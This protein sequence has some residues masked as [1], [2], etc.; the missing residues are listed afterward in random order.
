MTKNNRSL[1]DAQ[2]P[3]KTLIAEAQAARVKEHVRAV[4][5]QLKSRDAQS[6]RKAA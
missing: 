4:L 3:A 1:P 5:A 6:L 2:I